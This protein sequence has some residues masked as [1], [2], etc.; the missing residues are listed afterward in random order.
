MRNAE[1]IIDRILTETRARG[2]TFT[3]VLMSLGYSSLKRIVNG[4]SYQPS[5]G[6]GISITFSCIVDGK[7]INAACDSEDAI[8]PEIEA[9]FLKAPH[10]PRNPEDAFAPTAPFPTATLA[11]E[12]L[13]DVQT[14][15]MNDDH[16]VDVINHVNSLLE[17]AAFIFDGAV[18]QGVTDHFFANSVGT[19]QTCKTTNAHLSIFGFEPNDRS[20]SAYQT[21]AGKALSQFPVETLGRDV[22]KKLQIQRDYL[23]QHNGD[24]IDPFGGKTGPQRFDVIMERA[25]WAGL[26]AIFSG[27][28]SAWNGKSYHDGT[29]FFSGKLGTKVMGENITIWDDPFHSMGV[30]Q[31]FDYE[32]HPKQKLLLV[33]NGIAKNVAY[34]TALAH[35]YGT[36]TT[37]H[38]LPPSSRSFGAIPLHLSVQGGTATI[39]QMITDSKEP[40]LW[41]STLHYIRATHQQ[42]GRAT[43]TTLHGMFLVKNGEV[44][45]PT[46]HLRFDESIPEALSRVTHI[47]PALPTLSGEH[48]DTPYIVPTMRSNEFRFV[49]VADRT[50]R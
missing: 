26:L 31:A 2:A 8:T 21:V 36:V 17:P 12:L 42:D 23:T 11:P 32:G 30:P 33:K 37:G 10:L 18:A 4:E 41:I 20:V 40:T 46:E 50:V 24:R 44:V 13:Y 16:L 47:T 27:Q 6:E 35:K 39:K 14:A 29:S 25:G 7:R 22:A 9:L 34:D 28:A 1:S 15:Q 3:E 19:F 45:G 5:A 49:S 48:D 43:G 38:G